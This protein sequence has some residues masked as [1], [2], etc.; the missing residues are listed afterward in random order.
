[1]TW[2]S[3]GYWPPEPPVILDNCTGIP[4]LVSPG[5]HTK[6]P[7]ASSILVVSS[8]S[9]RSVA[10][11]G[12]AGS[13]PGPRCALLVL[14]QIRF[15]GMGRCREPS[16]PSLRVPVGA[17]DEWLTRGRRCRGPVPGP[18]CAKTQNTNV[19]AYV[20]G[21]AGDS[22]P[23][24]VARP[25][26]AGAST[27]GSRRCRGPVPGPRCACTVMWP[28]AVLVMWRCRGPAPALVA[29][30]STRACG[31]TRT[32]ALPGSHPRPSLRAVHV[33]GHRHWRGGV[34][35]DP[36][37]A[38]VV[39]PSP[40]LVPILPV[41]DVAGDPFP[42]LVVRTTNPKATTPS[43]PDVTGGAIPG[44]RCAEFRAFIRYSSGTGRCRAA[45]PGPHC[46]PQW[47]NWLSLVTKT[48]PG[49]GAVKVTAAAL[50]QA[51]TR[52]GPAP[53]R[54]L[55][56]LLRGSAAAPRTG[57]SWWRGLLVCAIDSTA[58]DVPDTPRPSTTLR[59]RPR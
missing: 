44:P 22:S 10:E 25:R 6:S 9:T 37:P 19:A 58:L 1:V 20:N 16:R 15:Y 29:R 38:L 46:A 55:F 13:H 26:P 23:A 32:R 41:R 50:W 3:T 59:T 48:L 57:G 21:V 51:R 5:R 35:G 47:T 2:E 18:R 52:L 12:V 27:T 33:D 56:D 43:G 53:L 54:L 40:Y 42:A 4:S 11:R 17:V 28:M 36:S 34:A 14:R 24:L 49:G 31:P 30:R 45:I 7:P 39:R 8:S